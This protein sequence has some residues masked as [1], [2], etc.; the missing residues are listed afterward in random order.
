MFTY[1]VLRRRAHY[2]NTINV[3][4]RFYYC[5]SGNYFVPF[6]LVIATVFPNATVSSKH[7]LTRTEDGSWE[8]DLE[9]FV[10]IITYWYSTTTTT[11]TTT[12]LWTL[13]LKDWPEV[14]EDV[15]NEH[16][17]HYEV[18][19]IERRAGV[20]TTLH[21][22]LFLGGVERWRRGRGIGKGTIQEL[23]FKGENTEESRRKTS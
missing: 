21:G 3:D 16:D 4:I 1:V 11:F 7:G 8:L 20:T 17:I 19:H 9:N 22:C 13:G 14:N 2:I 12:I 18:H 6:T 5:N 10:F 15:N 23:R